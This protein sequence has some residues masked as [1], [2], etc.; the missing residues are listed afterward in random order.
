MNELRR[1][2]RHVINNEAILVDCRINSPPQ[3]PPFAT[4]Q[5]I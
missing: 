2:H 1:R 4:C 5:T 3:P